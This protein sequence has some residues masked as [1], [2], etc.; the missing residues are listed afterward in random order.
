M[1]LFLLVGVVLLVSLLLRKRSNAAGG[2]API[3]PDYTPPADDPSLPAWLRKL[4]QPID[5]GADYDWSAV[6]D[7]IEAPIASGRYEGE[8]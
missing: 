3:L 6:P 7:G 4:A 1:R 2:V 8:D 5:W